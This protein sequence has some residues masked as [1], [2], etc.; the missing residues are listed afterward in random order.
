[1]MKETIQN[2]NPSSL[3]EHLNYFIQNM[4]GNGTAIEKLKML[5]IILVFIFIVKNNHHQKYYHK[6][7]SNFSSA[8]SSASSLSHSLSF[9]YG[10]DC[11]SFSQYPYEKEH[12]FPIGQHFHI[13][14]VCTFYPPILAVWCPNLM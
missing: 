11:T 6:I 4:I 14:K 3:N 10:I 2:Q 9:S 12:L 1:M 13:L 7:E 5:C 8:S